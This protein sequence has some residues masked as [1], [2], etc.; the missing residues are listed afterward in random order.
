MLRSVTAWWMEQ[1]RGL[2]PASLR[3]S[4][5]IRRPSLVIALEKPDLSSAELFLDGRNGRTALG[6]YSLSGT[7][8]REAVARLSAAQRRSTVLQL[9]PDLLLERDAILP[10]AAEPHLER[11]IAF[12]MDRLTPFRA[13]EVFWTCIAAQRDTARSQLHVRVTVVHRVRAEPI[14]AAL[15][16]AGLAPIRIEAAN[17]PYSSRAIPLGTGRTDRA[18]WSRRADTYAMGACAALAVL[19]IALPFILQSIAGSE[20]EARIDAVRPRVMEAA[21][22]RAKVADAATAADAMALARNQA[23]A[24]LQVIALLTD[25]LPDDTFL[26]MLS[27]QQRKLTFSGHSATAARLIGAMAAHPRLQNPTFTA[28]VIHDESDGGDSFS[29]RVELGA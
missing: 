23:G 1:M 18:W 28:P 2:V 27:A 14:L 4:A 12:E 15:G 19:A 26:T 8:L 17:A 3:L 29:I 6:R 11:V 25:V 13:E 10:L 9:P 5:W 20:M 21:S 16:Q 24:V 22:R 7:G